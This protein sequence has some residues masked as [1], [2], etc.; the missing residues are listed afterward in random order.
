MELPK[1]KDVEAFRKIL[2]NYKLSPEAHKVLLDTDLVLLI[3][4]TSAGRNTIINELVKTGRY[5]YLVSDTTRPK[6]YNNGAIEQDGVEY[7]F[8]PEE[9]ILSDLKAG[10]FLEAAIIHNQQ[11]SG[12]SIRE[13]KKA[14]E[15]RKI[16][17]S[18]VQPDGAE[19][20]WNLKP[21]AKFVFVLP[22]SFKVWMQRLRDRG[23]MS[24][25]EVRKRLESALTE[26]GSALE[27]P[28]YKL[29]VNDE[30][31]AC[32]RVIDAFFA[33]GRLNADDEQ[34][35]RGHATNLISDVRAFLGK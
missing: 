6:R 33:K 28:Y 34:H 13:L 16:A 1:L 4:P 32:T 12:M 11:V 23:A 19:S 24:E 26:I 14:W 3:G 9:D 7:W 35:A 31:H 27:R 22:P 8:R 17:V 25:E 2:Q 10:L 30:F 5:H 20:I 29:V 15:T 21:D 18:E